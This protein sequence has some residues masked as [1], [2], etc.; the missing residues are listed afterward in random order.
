MEILIDGRVCHAGRGE[1]IL[2]V[3]R[4]NDIYIPSLCHS[5]ALP[6]QGVCR[7]CMVEVIENGRRKV[8]ASCVY[9]IQ[10]EIEVI[11]DS[12]KII[13]MR[14]TIIMLLSAR[15]PENRE[16]EELREA[17]DVL[18]PQRF[19]TDKSEKCMLCG[20]CVRACSEVG[21]SAI[22]TVN[23]GVI[24]K[25]STPYDEPS[26]VCIGCGA[27]AGVCPA[28]AISLHEKDGIRT[29][30]K[31][32]FKLKVC[33]RCGRYYDTDEQL[34]HI[35]GKLDNTSEMALCYDCRRKATADNIKEVFKD[36]VK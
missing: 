18:K 28:G 34:K 6:G 23:R 1:Y 13:N 4:R 27:C 26:A 21:S 10:R 19:V 24:K 17:Y 11:T 7:L 5:S 22:A 15:M 31:R 3:A 12:K 36:I 8:V 9:P 20:L 25:V 32:E 29:I 33:E 30:W 16:I 2:D 14:K 35:K